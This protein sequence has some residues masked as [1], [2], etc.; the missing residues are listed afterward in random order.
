MTYVD[1]ILKHYEKL[2]ITR[3]GYKMLTTIE[4]LM[5]LLQ[6]YKAKQ[7][8]FQGMVGCP[9]CQIASACDDCPWKILNPLHVSGDVIESHCWSFGYIVSEENRR[10]A[11]MKQIRRWIVHYRT[12]LKRI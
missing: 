4:K 2:P 11:R 9:L 10:V 8:G 5:L 12:A 3:K 1:K 7:E 6:A